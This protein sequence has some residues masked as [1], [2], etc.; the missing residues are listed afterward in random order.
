VPRDEGERYA[1]CPRTAG[2]P[3]ELRRYDGMIHNFPLLYDALD[4]GKDAAGEIV[5]ALRAAFREPDR[6]GTPTA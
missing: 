5:T 4:R 1:M 2:T 6:I 3:V